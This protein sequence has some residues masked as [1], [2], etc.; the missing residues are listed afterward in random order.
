MRSAECVIGVLGCIAVLVGYF[1][2]I[3]ERIVGIAGFAAV[4]I[5]DDCDL[6]FAVVLMIALK[7]AGYYG[8]LL[9]TS[10]SPRDTR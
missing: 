7:V 5:G 1:A 8:C 2:D 3:S 6:V 10:P 9:Y 4:G